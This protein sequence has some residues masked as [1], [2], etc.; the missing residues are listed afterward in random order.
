M[1]K[2]IFAVIL[3]L[4][5]T[6]KAY[7]ASAGGPHLWLSI[8]PDN[9]DEGGVGYVGDSVN[10]WM[11]DSYH[12]ASGGPFRL[13]LYNA[14]NN[15]NVSPA[16]NVG[17]MVAIHSGDSGVVEIKDAFGNV[18]LISAFVYENINPY[19]GGGYHG[20]Y[21][22]VNSSTNEDGGDAVF[23]IYN[24]NITLAS[25]QSTYF[26]ITKHGLEEVHFDAFTQINGGSGFYNPASHDVTS[27]PEPATMSLLGLGLLGLLA[28][29]KLRTR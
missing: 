14:L 19:Y 23:A 1:K 26:D 6:V 12:A 22:N 8:N 21:R 28:R 17:L 4:V 13:Y 5:F 18:T 24:T 16:I 15:E 2:I 29:K 20:V 10:P 7:A 9:F 27:T 3:S 11:V 25:R